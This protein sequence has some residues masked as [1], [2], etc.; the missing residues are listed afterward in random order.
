MLRFLE[1]FEKIRLK[2]LL[3]IFPDCYTFL[4][5]FVTVGSVT[6]LGW[7]LVGKLHMYL[8][9][10]IISNIYVRDAIDKLDV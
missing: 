2:T 1:N 8:N 5:F 3:E 4:T 10:G 6:F 9:T 7:F